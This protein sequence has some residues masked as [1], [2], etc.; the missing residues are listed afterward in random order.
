M[1]HSID[2]HIQSLEVL[3]RICG[4]KADKQKKGKS[5]QRLV[6]CT[7]YREKILSTYGIDISED[8]EYVHPTKLCQPCYKLMF[9]ITRPSPNQEINLARAHDQASIIN[10][11]W[12]LP[13]RQ[14]SGLEC[15]ACSSYKNSQK[16]GCPKKKKR[17]GRPKMLNPTDNTDSDDGDQ[18]RPLS[19]NVSHL[20]DTVSVQSFGFDTSKTDSAISDTDSASDINLDLGIVHTDLSPK[21][22]K[23][24][25][26]INKLSPIGLKTPQTLPKNRKKL[27]KAAA[28]SPDPWESSSSNEEYPFT[29]TPEKS[30]RSK[31]SKTVYATPKKVLQT[32][33]T[34]TSPGIQPMTVDDIL[35]SDIRGKSTSEENKLMMHLTKKKLYLAPD[36]STIRIQNRRGQV[37]TV[38]T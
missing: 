16:P 35:Q 36:K 30:S 38:V 10:K 18:T 25:S 1:E 26:D 27:L 14:D 21:T 5:C 13:K 33:A 22:S 24:S 23:L 17:V 4:K 32:S 37:C 20:S 8:S 15:F 31:K 2:V 9:S 6:F 19:G 7:K 34:Q 12:K 28:Q 29:S 3:C 11:K